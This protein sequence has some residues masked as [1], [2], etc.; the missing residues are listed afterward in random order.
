MATKFGKVAMCVG[1]NRVGSDEHPILTY[2]WNSEGK[3]HC[4]KCGVEVI[5][6][7]E[8]DERE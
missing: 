7:D 6:V 8:V 3:R 4:V 1:C 2:G 5:L